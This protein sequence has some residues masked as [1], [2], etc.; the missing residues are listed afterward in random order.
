MPARRVVDRIAPAPR[1]S[2]LEAAELGHQPRVIE[3]FDSSGVHRREKSSVQLALRLLGHLVRDPLLAEPLAGPF[4]A[5]A[6]A[7]DR[8]DPVGREQLRELLHHGFGRERRSALPD[9]VQDRLP[10]GMMGDG[11][12]HGVLGA[13]GGIYERDIGKVRDGRQLPPPTG[14]HRLD[15]LAGDEG[16]DVP[17]ELGAI[18]RRRGDLVLGVRLG[19]DLLVHRGV[20]G[21]GGSLP[22]EDRISPFAVVAAVGIPQRSSA[23]VWGRDTEQKGPRNRR[24]PGP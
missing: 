16:L 23:G 21:P 8:R 14:H 17:A 24:H 6:V 18:L 3:E 4:A 20:H 10:L 9:G 13:A 12:R 5:V 22:D 1:G 11:K 2:S 19:D 7:R 15:G